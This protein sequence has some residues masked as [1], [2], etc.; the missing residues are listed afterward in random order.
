LLFKLLSGLET[1]ASLVT[2]CWSSDSSRFS[3]L[4]RVR[5][6]GRARPPSLPLSR[7]PQGPACSSTN[8][9]SASWPVPQARESPTETP[10]T[11][12]GR[13]PRVSRDGA[14]PSRRDGAARGAREPQN[15]PGAK[16]ERPPASPDAAGRAGEHGARVTTLCDEPLPRDP[17]LRRQ[18]WRTGVLQCAP[19]TASFADQIFPQNNHNLRRSRV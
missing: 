3:G 7:Q 8:S 17:S 1:S 15:P 16:A 2:D 18:L 13:P 12:S 4:L 11:P 19:G 14:S 5:R 6:P 9:I 10:V